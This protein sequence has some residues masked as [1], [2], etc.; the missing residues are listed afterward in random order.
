MKLEM[1]FIHLNR[2]Q[3]ECHC[4]RGNFSDFGT[5]SSERT[6]KMGRWFG[7]AEKKQTL[8][9]LCNRKKVRAKPKSTRRTLANAIQFIRLLRVF[10]A[11]A[12]LSV[13]NLW[14]RTRMGAHLAPIFCL[15]VVIR[16]R[17]TDT[18]IRLVSRLTFVLSCH[19]RVSWLDQNPG[20]SDTHN[21]FK[22]N[23]NAAKSQIIY[24][25]KTQ[26]YRLH[27]FH[28]HEH[29]DGGAGLDVHYTSVSSPSTIAKCTTWRQKLTW[30]QYIYGN[31][32][33]HN[34]ERQSVSKRIENERSAVVCALR[35]Y[36]IK[37]MIFRW[38]GAEIGC[39]LNEME[40]AKW[41]YWVNAAQGVQSIRSH[42]LLQNPITSIVWTAERK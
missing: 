10:C 34:N 9:I 8:N 28:A 3:Y 36:C 19:C 30:L 5:I 38:N 20:T 37:D 15:S 42:R 41:Q 40:R 7:H 6:I 14:M 12:R 33:C 18:M 11:F 21:K 13:N 31:S 1:I 22:D 27:I 39:N 35:Y 17:K 26:P 2:P 25:E 4:R 16:R 23:F 29:Y 32:V 24:W